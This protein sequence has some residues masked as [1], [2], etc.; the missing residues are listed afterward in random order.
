MLKSGDYT[1]GECLISTLKTMHP[2]I[3]SRVFKT[4]KEVDANEKY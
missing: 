1:I 4:L 3:K 2:V